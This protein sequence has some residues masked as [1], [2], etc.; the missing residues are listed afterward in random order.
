[1]KAETRQ[2]RRLPAL[3]RE[4]EARRGDQEPTGEVV[5]KYMMRVR[6]PTERLRGIPREQ[7]G[8]EPDPIDVRDD[9]A[10]PQPFPV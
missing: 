5:A 8:N 1:M 9:T 10:L 7:L 2:E 6:P 3:R 4:Q